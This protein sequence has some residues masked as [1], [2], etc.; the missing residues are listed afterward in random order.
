M[1]TALPH[2]AA[3]CRAG[4]AAPSR[5][6]WVS[7]PCPLPPGSAGLL[8]RGGGSFFLCSE[9]ADFLDFFPIIDCLMQIG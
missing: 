7:C 6:G 8:L 3:P 5:R 9:F 1:L 4:I 2:G